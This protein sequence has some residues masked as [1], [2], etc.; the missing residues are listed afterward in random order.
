MKIAFFGTPEFAK[1]ILSDLFYNFKEIEIKL[2]VSQPDKP[3]GR[4]KEILKTKTAEFAT[5]NN[6]ELMQPETLKN[7]IEFLNKL[8]SLNLDFIVVVAYGK[9]IPQ[10]I[11]DIP[12]YSC[13]NIHGSILPNYR[14][15]SPVQE[16]LKAGDKKTGI[17]I[18]YMSDKMDEGD[19]LQIK[20]VEIDIKDKSQDIFKK[21]E[22]IGAGLLVD[23]LK[24]VVNK[25]ITPIKQDDKFATY[26]KKI[27]KNDGKIDFKNSSSLEIYNK[28]R[29]YS[30][31]P[32]IFTYYFEKKLDITDCFF[33]ESI[34]E[35]DKDFSPGDVVEI[36]FDSKKNIAVLCKTGVLIINKVKLEGKKEISIFDFINGNKYFLNYNFK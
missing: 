28:F 36:E 27:E 9:I 10:N 21:F 33:D 5:S 6:L 20:E 22:K 12:K 16:S 1:N 19:I 34:V 31:W 35:F 4:K 29:S 18:M 2:V 24:K 30:P 17:T 32:G 15:A 8:K 25:T 11:L 7:N 26:C 23:T 3:V 14:G 13:I